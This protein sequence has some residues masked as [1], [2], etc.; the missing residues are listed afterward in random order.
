MNTA[1]IAKETLTAIITVTIRGRILCSAMRSVTI[2][3]QIG[4]K[5]TYPMLSGKLTT[6]MEQHDEL[7]NEI[8]Y[9][10]KRKV[11]YEACEDKTGQHF[12]F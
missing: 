3:K 6:V 9:Q 2:A 7:V 8:E 4:K 5:R 10:S 1:I 12:L 11:D